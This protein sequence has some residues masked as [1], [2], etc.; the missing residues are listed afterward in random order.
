MVRDI[1]PRSPFEPHSSYNEKGY[2]NTKS[3]LLEPIAKG[4]FLI[5]KKTPHYN[6]VQDLMSFVPLAEKGS[7][8]SIDTIQ[9]VSALLV[10]LWLVAI[11]IIR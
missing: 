9:L 7:I 10:V 11:S 5:Y 2:D 3:L 8:I 1:G 6:V 4:T